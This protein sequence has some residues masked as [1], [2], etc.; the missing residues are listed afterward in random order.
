MKT[1]K[2][3]IVWQKSID[4]VTEI[5]KIT[6]E[7]PKE[8]SYGIT[9]QIRRSSVSIPSNIA[10]S[11]GRRS[12]KEYVQF[13]H[14]ALGSLSELETQILIASNLKYINK[15]TNEKL[16]NEIVT[17]IRMLTSLIAKLKSTPSFVN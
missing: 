7:F 14:I 13:L 3:L 12:K 8:E 5:Y 4:L 15:E 2:D 10:E 17:L 1:H 16:N 11:A 6:K 9:S